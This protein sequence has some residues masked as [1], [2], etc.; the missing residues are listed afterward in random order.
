M[1][2]VKNTQILIAIVDKSTQLTVADIAKYLNVPES[3]VTTNSSPKGWRVNLTP[4]AA[5][6]LLA[7]G[8]DTLNGE[9]VNFCENDPSCTVYIKGVTNVINDTD[10]KNA[11]KGEGN[12][13]MTS[14]PRDSSHKPKGMSFVR[15]NRKLDALRVA[16]KH[17]SLFLNGVNLECSKFDESV[18]RIVNESASFRN[19]PESYGE[20]ELLNLFEGYGTVKDIRINQESNSGTVYFSSPGSVQRAV[21]ALNGKALVMNN[22]FYISQNDDQTRRATQYNNLYVGNIDPSVTEDELRKVFSQYGEIESLLLPTRRIKGE[23]GQPSKEIRKNF[24]YISFRDSKAASNVIKEMDSRTYWGRDLD[25]D[26]YKDRDSRRP[27]G[28]ISYGYRN[29]RDGNSVGGQNLVQDFANAMM[30]MMTQFNAMNMRG[31]GG[32]GGPSSG[33]RGNN[34][35]RNTRGNNRGG[36]RGNRG[37]GSMR[38]GG[39][40]PA[41]SQY[42]H[43]KTMMPNTMSF[44]PMGSM[45]SMPPMSQ[46]PMS[47]PPMTQ[48]PM[49][50]PPM[51]QP[52]MSQPPMSQPPMSQPPMTQPP[53][54]H[55]PM[56]QPPMSQPPMTQPPMSQ[57]PMTQPPMS[58]PPISQ[59]PMTQPPMFNQSENVMSQPPIVNNMKPQP[60]T[61][62]GDNEDSE[63]EDQLFD[64]GDVLKI[65]MDK[66]EESENEIG[67]F[68]YNKI[69]LSH[70]SELAGKITGMFLDIPPEELY[71]IIHSDETYTRYIK[72]AE[73]LINQ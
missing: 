55:P 72:D 64:Q 57:P 73:E 67:T 21:Q 27:P 70:G 53:M 29:N 65:P 56:S 43:P 19:V 15:F 66:Y 48:P 36:T 40:Y 51:S 8:L 1:E 49:T 30:A 14:I 24:I 52:P 16:E 26:Y 41:R 59:P 7:K 47:Q 13:C 63:K 5:E 38:G 68:L 71:Q 17:S 50:Q 61:P 45:G 60:P 69:E 31:R 37:R 18:S 42:E 39:Y 54:S 58:Q 28:N 22:I 33:Y 9:D 11:L 25:I 20:Q 10:L 4:T 32:Y 12:I 44:P 2:E 23:S 3:E 62:S 34:P 6:E 46:P 35:Y